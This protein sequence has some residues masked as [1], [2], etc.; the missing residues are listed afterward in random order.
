[1]NETLS[2]ESLANLPYLHLE[3]PMETMHNLESNVH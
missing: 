3:K 2:V 1:M